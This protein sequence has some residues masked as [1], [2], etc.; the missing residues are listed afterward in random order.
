MWLRAG[1]AGLTFGTFAL[2]QRNGWNM[3][4]KRQTKLSLVLMIVLTLV[5]AI[6]VGEWITR[7]MLFDLIAGLIE[8]RVR[9]VHL[10]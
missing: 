7:G 8:G 1:N 3:I 5:L 2:R 6:G 9:F 4:T 10:A